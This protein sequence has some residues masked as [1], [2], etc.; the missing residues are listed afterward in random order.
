MAC[1]SGNATIMKTDIRRPTSTIT[2]KPNKKIE[3]ATNLLIADD[4]RKLA[5]CIIADIT[6]RYYVSLQNEIDKISPWNNDKLMASSQNRIKAC[7]TILRKIA[8]GEMTPPDFLEQQT[9]VMIGSDLIVFNL[10]YSIVELA[11]ELVKREKLARQR[12]SK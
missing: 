6:A 10:A 8:Q 1:F 12:R 7:R 3:D 4:V 5:D 2:P 9:R 11:S